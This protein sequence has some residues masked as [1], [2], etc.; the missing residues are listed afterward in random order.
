MYVCMYVCIYVCMYLC[1]CMS[2][3]SM[4]MYTLSICVLLVQYC[5]CNHTSTQTQMSGLD[6]V[7]QLS[8]LFKLGFSTLGK[9]SFPH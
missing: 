7:D 8:F 9:V 4:Y 2:M 6:I 3:Q 5:I 1:I